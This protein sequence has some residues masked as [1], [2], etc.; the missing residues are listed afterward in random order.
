VAAAAPAF[1]ADGYVRAALRD[2]WTDLALEQRMRRLS[3]L[4][5]QRLPGAYRRQFDV[6]ERIAPDFTG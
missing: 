6:P 4:L 5:G 2:G 3:E 1:D